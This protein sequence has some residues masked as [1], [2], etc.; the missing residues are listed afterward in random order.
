MISTD[1]IPGELKRRHAW[2]E[3]S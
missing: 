2:G 1:T 3:W